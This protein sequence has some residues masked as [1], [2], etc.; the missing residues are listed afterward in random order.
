MTKNV[1]IAISIKYRNDKGQWLAE[2]FCEFVSSLKNRHY[3]NCTVIIDLKRKK[4]IKCRDKDKADYDV[5]IEHVMKNYTAQY[6]KLADMYPDLNLPE[7]EKEVP[8]TENNP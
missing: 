4:I 8:D 5:Q 1:F 2:E 6:E 7:V 3:E